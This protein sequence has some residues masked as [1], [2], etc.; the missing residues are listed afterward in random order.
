M[1]GPRF[2]PVAIEDFVVPDDVGLGHGRQGRCGEQQCTHHA[3]RRGRHMRTD[4]RMERHRFNRTRRWLA[5]ALACAMLGAVPA[6]TLPA[7]VSAANHTVR[8]NPMTF[9]PNDLTIVAGDT[10]TFVNG[11]GL[12]NVRSENGSITSFRCAVGC[13]GNNGD[14]STDP[15]TAV[16]RF[17]TAGTIRYFC[18]IHGAPGG[19]GMSG[20]IR[21]TAAPPPPPPPPPAY[22]PYADFNADGRSDLPWRNMQTGVSRIWRSANSGSSIALAT[23]SNLSWRIVGIGDFDNNNVADVLWRNSGNGVNVIWR[24]ANAATQTSLATVPNQQWKVVGVG[25]FNADRRS[26]IVWRNDVTGANTIWLSANAATQMHV[27]TV[28]NLQWRIVGVGDFNRDG[29]S[30]LLWRN[31]ATGANTIWRSGS[32]ATQQYVTTVGIAWQAVGVGD[33]NGDGFSDI[34]WRHTGGGNIIWRS[35]NAQLPIYAATVTN[36]A[37]RIVAIGDFNGD[38]RSDAVWRNASS[39]GNTIWL[40][41]NG[42]TQQA[43]SALLAPW[44][45]VP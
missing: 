26:D 17:P 29:R 21:V 39:G 33:F 44:A 41:G 30:D 32:S 3:K 10:V 5:W 25:D 42:S 35:A 12:H 19:V 24:S 23:V 8:A 9:S 6:L 38:R 14:P 31:V 37:W 4:T 40:S 18:E 16:V 20:I 27:T 45:V 36:Q 28:T 1:H 11:G 34:F 15:W 43:V 22:R 7:T 13:D 2:E